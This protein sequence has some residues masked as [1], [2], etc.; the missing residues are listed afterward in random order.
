MAR[1]R[2]LKI[3]TPGAQATNWINTVPKCPCDS[4]ILNIAWK[5]WWLHKLRLKNL[6]YKKN[7]WGY[8][9]YKFEF[10]FLTSWGLRCQTS[11]N[12]SNYMCTV[13]KTYH[14]H[15]C[16]MN[17][18]TYCDQA[19]AS[20]TTR[21]STRTTNGTWTT[22]RE[23]LNL[24]QLCDNSFKICLLRSLRVCTV[25]RDNYILKQSTDTWK[26]YYFPARCEHTPTHVNSAH[27]QK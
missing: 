23:P 18:N 26:I 2:R 27:I 9:N 22:F 3:V 4:S 17:A 21:G 25:E 16:Y 19:F 11:I 7:T 10:V 20:C 24:T 12:I 8:F 13:F 15:N 5:Y 1:M 6:F 14:R